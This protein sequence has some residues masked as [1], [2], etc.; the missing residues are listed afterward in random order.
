MFELPDSV[1][2]INKKFKTTKITTL[3]RAKALYMKRYFSGS[4]M[5]DEMTGG[6]FASKRIIM[7]FGAR[8]AGKNA[9]LNQTAAF[10]QR[11]CRTCH[12]VLPEFYD[13]SIED[14]WTSILKYI[15]QTPICACK[16]P[17]PKKVLMVDYEGD[18]ALEE[19]RIVKL[20]R[21]T[22]KVNGNE[23]DELDY[24]T[25]KAMLDELKTKET[26]SENEKQQVK[27][28]EKWIKGLQFEEQE[29]EHLATQD[30]LKLCG[31]LTD[32]LLV[33]VPEDVEEGIEMIR[34]IIQSND[35]DMIIWNSLQGSVTRYVREREAGQ[36]DMGSEAKAN[37]KLMRYAVSAYAPK[38]LEDPA[39]AYK[40]TL[41]ITSQVRS[42][43]GG[44]HATPDSF[45]G[46]NAIGHHSIFILEVK[47]DKWL[48]QDG[49]D[50]TFKDNFYGQQVRIRAEKSKLAA[51]VGDML[52]Y[53]YYFRQGE[54]NSIG[55]DHI[56]E[57][58]SLGVQKGLIERS[59]AFYKT[60]GEQFQGMAKLI[61]FFKANPKFV[62]EL[63]Q[64][65]KIK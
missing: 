57:I 20:T 30:Y 28:I 44:F 45:S 35:V 51:S 5:V 17:N 8:S 1:K 32:K 23:I 36:S 2:E 62:G 4:F 16:I 27:D 9:L 21:I 7:I 38:D 61:E 37:G 48:K 29:I 13:A 59:G 31:I 6:G 3:D 34:P 41:F 63:Y 11:R 40:P 25:K 56:G 49:T 15:L 46:G 33:S 39:Q 10:T 60:K 22:E 52:T 43:I 47:R 53:D 65:I 12:G 50:A 64:D 26:L 58:V 18:L 14:R 19:P 55:I 42:T 24:N 54:T